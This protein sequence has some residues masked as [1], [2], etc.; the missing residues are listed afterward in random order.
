M[1]TRQEREDA[2]RTREE[3]AKDLAAIL[4]LTDLHE[5]TRRGIAWKMIWDFTEV[6]GK[7]N[8]SYQW[9]DAAF[10]H[11]A[12]TGSYTGLRREHSCPM[13][14]TIPELLAVTAP[15]AKKLMRLLERAAAVCVLTEAEDKA[16]NKKYKSCMPPGALPDDILARY[17]AMKI[18]IKPAP[19]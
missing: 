18:A 3:I 14:L 4:A 8:K 13:S 17:T 7:W 1:A 5:H 15:T 19:R 9:S 10:K 16:L 12:T 2:K 11:Y 6:G